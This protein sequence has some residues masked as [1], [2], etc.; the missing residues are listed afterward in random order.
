MMFAAWVHVEPGEEVGMRWGWTE[1]TVSSKLILRSFL[2]ITQ[3]RAAQLL[4]TQKY[5]KEDGQ[6]THYDDPLPDSVPVL[7]AIRPPAA[8]RPQ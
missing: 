3:L 2:A 5:K 4:L 6:V 1:M 7:S 8:A